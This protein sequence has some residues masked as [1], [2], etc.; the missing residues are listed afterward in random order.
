MRGT[1]QY[2]STIDRE[3]RKDREVA[4]AVMPW[5][6]ESSADVRLLDR[7]AGE[8]SRPIVSEALYYFTVLCQ[9]VDFWLYTV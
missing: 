2:A 6:V 9:S 5:S 4:T 3:P 8:D 7:I 1:A